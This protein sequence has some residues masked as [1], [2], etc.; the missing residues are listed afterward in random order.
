MEQQGYLT[1]Y[2]NNHHTRSLILNSQYRVGLYLR[3]SKD[4]G[5][6]SDNS[7]IVTQEML[8]VKF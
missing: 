8:G 2:T 3:F 5:K 7:S 4:D 1:N 6:T